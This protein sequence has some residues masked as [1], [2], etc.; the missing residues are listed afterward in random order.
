M[1]VEEPSWDQ[2]DVGKDLI[3]ASDRRVLE[4][5]PSCI[6]CYLLKV[7]L[8]SHSTCIPPSLLEGN[9]SAARKISAEVNVGA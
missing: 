1:E 6:T 8:R 9:N 3:C 2:M 5:Q 7:A 4:L